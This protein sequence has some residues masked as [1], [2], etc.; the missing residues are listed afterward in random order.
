MNL[1]ETVRARMESP[2][3]K[4]AMPACGKLALLDRGSSRRILY[5]AVTVRRVSAFTRVREH[6]CDS[7]SKPPGPLQHSKTNKQM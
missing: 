5:Q 4:Y 3:L 2:R 7:P 6:Q 1:L